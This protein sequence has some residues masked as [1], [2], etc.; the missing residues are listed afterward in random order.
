MHRQEEDLVETV[1]HELAH[2]YSARSGGGAQPLLEEGL[3]TW[4]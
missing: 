3:A 4:L 2:L 1:R